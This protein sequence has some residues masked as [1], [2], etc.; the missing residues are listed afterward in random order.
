MENTVTIREYQ[1]GDQESFRRLNE[2]WILRHFS[3]EPKDQHALDDP[4]ETILRCG[5]RIF[6]AVQ[7]AK[8]VGCCAL[9]DAG[10]G[11]YEVAK[12]AVTAAARGRGIGRLLL[13]R[14]IEAA[15]AAGANR[16]FLETNHALVPAIRLYESMGFRHLEPDRRRTSDYARSDVQMEMRFTAPVLQAPASRPLSDQP[17]RAP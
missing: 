2:E 6:F 12:M 1:P 17:D 13:A 8:T 10:A 16:L 14:I 5:G 4:E 15:Q 7:G 11:E 3:M 9:L